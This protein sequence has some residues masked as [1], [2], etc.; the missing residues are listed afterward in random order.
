[1]KLVKILTAVLMSAVLPAIAAAATYTI[2][3]DHSSIQFKVK[4]LM[5][6]NVKGGFGKVSGTVD[7]DDKDI[8]KSRTSVSIE[9][10]SIDTG[11]AKRD[12]HLRS[13]ISV[14]NG[15]FVF[16]SPNRLQMR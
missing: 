1:M 5:V 7:I 16:S 13:A 8:S 4:H 6:S 11:V 15:V 9:T 2:D 10:A 3:P 14:S 12:E